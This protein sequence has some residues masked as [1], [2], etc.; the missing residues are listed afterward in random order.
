MGGRYCLSLSSVRYN[1]AFQ[2]TFYDKE[3]ST[4]LMYFTILEGGEKTLACISKRLPPYL[5]TTVCCV[6]MYV[7]RL[8]WCLYLVHLV[9]A[10]SDC[11]A[12]VPKFSTY[13]MK[14]SICCKG[15]ILWNLVSDYVNDSYKSVP[16]FWE[17][18]FTRLSA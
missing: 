10:I 17:I 4:K 6:C 2:P 7:K 11:T 1:K 12:V 14:K 9:H 18:R 5:G 16:I 13:F 3:Q 8:F 15:A